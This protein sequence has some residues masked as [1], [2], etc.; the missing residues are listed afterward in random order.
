MSTARR[1]T[2]RDRSGRITRTAPA[3]TSW[4]AAYAR[5]LARHGLHSQAARAARVGRRTAER[6]RARFPEFAA[7][8]EGALDELIELVELEVICQARGIKNPFP[9]G[10]GD[11]KRGNLTA[12]I[13]FLKSRRP[14]LYRDNWRGR[15]AGLDLSEFGVRSWGELM[16]LD[17][18]TLTD[19]QLERIAGRRKK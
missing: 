6:H 12:C 9:L 17:F 18:S 1:V 4:H 19:E 13:C 14:E 3:D 15:G 5:E 11:V 16:D 2:G 8:C 10:E 7:A